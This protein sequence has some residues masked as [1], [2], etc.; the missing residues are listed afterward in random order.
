MNGRLEEWKEGGKAVSLE[1]C[2][3]IKMSRE[4]ILGIDPQ[5]KVRRFIPT[6]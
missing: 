2:F 6:H 3:A 1:R 4:N 5:K